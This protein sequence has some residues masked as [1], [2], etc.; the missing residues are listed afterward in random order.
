MGHAIA[1]TSTTLI[2]CVLTYVGTTYGVKKFDDWLISRK[3]AKA[4]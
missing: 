1:K 3:A 4:A 2:V